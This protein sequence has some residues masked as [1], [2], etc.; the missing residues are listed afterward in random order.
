MG[1]EGR[2]NGWSDGADLV[3]ANGPPASILA[4]VKLNRFLKQTGLAGI[5][6]LLVAGCTGINTQQ[7]LSPADFLMPG[8]TRLLHMQ[9]GPVPGPLDQ[10][11]NSVSPGPAGFAQR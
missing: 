7:T 5:L 2:G 10:L 9:N 1:R 3:V 11:T 4:S 6:A 8:A